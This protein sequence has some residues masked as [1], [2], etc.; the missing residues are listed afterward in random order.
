MK[1]AKLDK[2]FAGIKTI[3]GALTPLSADERVRALRWV[4]DDLKIDLGVGPP[5]GAPSG[6]PAASSAVAP[7]VQGPPGPDGSGVTPK[8]F[9]DSKKPDYDIERATC[10]AYYLTHYRRMA[11]FTTR[12]LSAINTDARGRA[13]SNLS[14][15]ATNAVGA[16]YLA[17]A[18]RGKRRI[19][20]RGE[21]VVEAL[22]DREKVAEALKA[23]RIRKKRGRR[24]TAKSGK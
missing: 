6:S 10:L 19:T 21:A 18:G 13:F 5:S 9:M 17:P 23:K 7:H 4:L 20:D 3:I 15:A 1:K 16:G 8:S 11:A 22:P 2:L 14:M 12:D 24:K